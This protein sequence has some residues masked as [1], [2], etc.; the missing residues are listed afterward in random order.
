MT[1]AIKESAYAIQ[2]VDPIDEAQKMA[3]DAAN[4]F[5]EK[6]GEQK[7]EGI[8]PGQ[9][10]EPSRCVL[11]N[12]FNADC[13]VTYAC[14]PEGAFGRVGFEKEDHA[15]SF[16]EAVNEVLDEAPGDVPE[17]ERSVVYDR[18]GVRALE[19]QSDGYSARDWWV[20]LASPMAQIAVDFDDE[21]LDAELEQ[22]FW[23]YKEE[24]AAAA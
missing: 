11:A 8:I 15:R 2:P 10:S 4:R 22:S 14:G 5:R 20:T 7:I 9:M 13:Y 6:I 24:D 12:T 1:D 17:N 19:P 23:G 21:A 3:L 16:A 18:P